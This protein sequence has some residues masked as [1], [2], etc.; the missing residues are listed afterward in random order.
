[1]NFSCLYFQYQVIGIVRNMLDG[2]FDYEALVDKWPDFSAV[3]VKPKDSE[4]K[5][6]IILVFYRLILVD[7]CQEHCKKAFRINWTWCFIRYALDRNFYFAFPTA[8][9]HISSGSV[10]QW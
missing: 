9:A 1:M 6:K 10:R 3:V 7:M 5:V 8:D 4:Y 2:K